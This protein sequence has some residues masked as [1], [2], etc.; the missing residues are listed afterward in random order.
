[1][2]RIGA[3]FLSLLSLGLL[4]SPA[5][6]QTSNIP[7]YFFQRATVTMNCIQAGFNPSE[8]TSPGLRFVISPASVSAAT[9]IFMRPPTAVAAGSQRSYAVKLASMA[10]PRKYASPITMITTIVMITFT[11]VMK[12]S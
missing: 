10:Q 12:F 9:A 1:M 11:S 3:F 6:A 5:T 7:A 8:Q 4:I 2:L